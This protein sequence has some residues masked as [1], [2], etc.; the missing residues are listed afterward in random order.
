MSRFL[1]R[2]K[3]FLIIS[4]FLSIAVLFIVWFAYYYGTKYDCIP[5]LITADGLLGYGGTLVATIASV[6]LGIVA[7]YQSYVSNELNVK[8]MKQND[9]INKQI[10]EKTVLPYIAIKRVHYSQHADGLSAILGS[11]HSDDQVQEPQDAYVP[12][13]HGVVYSEADITEYFIVV[14]E[15][16]IEMT[17]K[18]PDCISQY[19]N[20]MFKQKVSKA[21]G[22]TVISA[23]NREDTYIPVL[24]RNIGL[25]NMA[26]LICGI[27][28]SGL[29]SDE[30]QSK[31]TMTN[32]LLINEELRFNI[33]FGESV[34]KHN[35]YILRFKYANIYGDVYVQEYSLTK[36]T[37][38]LDGFQQKEEKADS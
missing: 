19:K 14:N 37:F 13:E 28:M 4:A 27:F 5:T 18:D 21:N 2:Y 23:H 22:I 3:W 6:F 8:L 36:N 1:K 30:K 38:D 34:D 10:S 32:Q 31:S 29:E 16:S 26:W 24:A 15:D 9:D 17:T 20:N 7:L 35:K 12:A 25:G 33:Y 11:N